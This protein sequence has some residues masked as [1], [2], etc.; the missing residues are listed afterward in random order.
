MT[1][2]QLVPK[3]HESAHFLCRYFNIFRNA[4]DAAAAADDGVYDNASH[5]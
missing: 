2:M 4:I 3:S 1:Q 5:K